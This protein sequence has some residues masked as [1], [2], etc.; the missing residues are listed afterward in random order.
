[1]KKIWKKV[2]FLKENEREMETTSEGDKEPINPKDKIQEESEPTDEREESSKK[3]QETDTKETAPESK[4][5]NVD[6]PAMDL[7]TVPSGMKEVKVAYDKFVSLK[8]TIGALKERIFPREALSPEE[9]PRSQVPK[10]PRVCLVKLTKL[11]HKEMKVPQNEDEAKD[12]ASK[13]V[14]SDEP[15]REQETEQLSCKEPSEPELNPTEKEQESQ[16]EH[17]S[18]QESLDQTEKESTSRKN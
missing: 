12:V 13:D 14:E 9:R 16:K 15:A 5:Q 18:A 17:D 6:K 11:T 10:E 1:M 4:S 7:S 3:K 2:G 8:E